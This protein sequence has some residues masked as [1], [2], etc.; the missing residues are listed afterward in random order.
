LNQIAPVVP[1]QIE[2]WLSML[3]IL[4]E[5]ALQTPSKT[6]TMMTQTKILM[7]STG[8]TALASLLMVQVRE[9]IAAVMESNIWTGKIFL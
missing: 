5:L 7:M 9:L 3:S 8:L 2:P 6:M 4:L 1:Q